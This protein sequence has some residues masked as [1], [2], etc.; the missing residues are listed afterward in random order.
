MSRLRICAITERRADYSR[1]R[2]V[3]QLMNETPEIEL[4]LVVTGQHLVPSLGNTVADIERDGLPIVA[5]IPSILDDEDSGSAMVRALGVILGGL[6][7]T[8]EEFRPDLVLVCVDLGSA[9]AGAIAGA[10]M[11]IPVAHLD[12]GAVT[13][14]IDESIRHAT[15]KFS[16]IHFACT[17]LAA[18]RVIKMGELERYVFNVG[19]PAL[20]IVLHGPRIDVD[21]LAARLGLS[22]DR[23]LVL[24]IQHAVTTQAEQ[25]L[26]QFLVT[27]EA[28]QRVKEPALLVYPNIDAGGRRII[29]AI[30]GSSIKHMPHVAFEEFVALMSLSNV[31][32]GNSSAGIREAASFALPVVNIGIRQQ[33]R[34]RAGNVI[35]VDHDVDQ[36]E[37]AI[38]KALTDG[39]FRQRMK[40]APNPY[41]DG[42][43]AERIVEILLALDLKDPL[44][45]QKKLTY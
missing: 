45:I 8:L 5:R 39:E 14:S 36:I 21:L 22:T 19:D 10:H 17:Q 6:A 18:Q 44:L 27:L 7:E 12:G 41:G 24:V 32:V 9:V 26:D 30:E 25:S 40:E 29:A 34:E 33:G 23:P 1:I 3:Y 2:S 20:D 35:D 16:N 4:G 42:H 11:N 37:L 15:T 13:G 38:Q 43:A 28:V 31:M